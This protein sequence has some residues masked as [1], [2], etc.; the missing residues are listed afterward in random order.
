[1]KRALLEE[2]LHKSET[3][4]TEEFNAAFDKLTEEQQKQLI[5]ELVEDSNEWHLQIELMTKKMNDELNK[6]K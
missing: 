6:K 3:L 5:D 2:F 1:M 4:S